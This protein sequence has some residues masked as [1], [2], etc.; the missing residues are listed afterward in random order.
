[1][2]L[3]QVENYKKKLVICV[4]YRNREKH[5][6]IFF[7]HIKNYFAYDKL[8]KYLNVSI[9]FTEQNNNKPFNLGKL[10]N[11]C[12]KENKNELD[13]IVINNVDF[14]PIFADYSYS[15]NPTVLISQG[16]DRH[17]IK[18]SSKFI[19]KLKQPNIKYIFHG[20]VLIPK[21]IFESVNGYSNNFW[22]WGYEDSD[23]RERLII[24]NYEIHYRQG[25]YQPLLHDNLGWDIAKNTEIIKTPINIKNNEIFKKN[26][27]D[28]NYY[29][30][31][32]LSSLK[33]QKIKEEIKFEN[34]REGSKFIIKHIKVDF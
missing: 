18:P 1:M 25:L 20:S 3:N 24:N 15:N 16:Y 11:I 23:M 31:D 6:K 14:L 5:Y 29:K 26:W 27:Q 8:D 30:K 12:F 10:N 4:P 17:P 19:N 33:Y 13:Y 7:S 9:V 22:G 32:G 34:F 21:K 28:K 2:I